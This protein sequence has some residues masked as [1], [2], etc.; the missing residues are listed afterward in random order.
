MTDTRRIATGW[1]DEETMTTL[2]SL[3]DH[4]YEGDVVD[5]ADLARVSDTNPRSVARWK[6]EAATP[7]R[8]AEERLLELRAVV[9]LARRVMRDDAARFW[10]RSPN[11]DLGY[12]KP[13]DVIAAGQYQRVVAELTRQ[14]ERQG[15]DVDALLPRELLEISADLDKVLD[16]TDTATLD[17]LGIAPPDLVREDHRFTQEIGEAAHEHAFQAIRSP[18]ATGVDLVLAIFPEKLAG[19]VLDGTLLGEWNTPD[20]LAHLAP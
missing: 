17:A 12:E 19:A 3:L 4:L 20:D 15:L 7:R 16:L 10:M 13:L 2:T 14:A 5:T 11:P 8:D 9:D 6:A 18:S 1:G